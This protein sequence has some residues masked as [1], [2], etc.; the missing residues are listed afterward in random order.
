MH[1]ARSGARPAWTQRVLRCE[2]LDV[3]T[4][5][6]TSTSLRSLTELAT[7]SATSVAP[8]LL[9][10]DDRDLTTLR[11]QGITNWF[12]DP[13][14]LQYN[15]ECD[16][17]HELTSARFVLSFFIPKRTLTMI[18]RTARGGHVGPLMALVS[19]FF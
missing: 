18:F 11:F 10:G 5:S 13:W 2:L 15:F 9:R 17:G 1:R 7:H 19:F 16:N 4:T 3:S 8:G 14:A 6:S 12:I